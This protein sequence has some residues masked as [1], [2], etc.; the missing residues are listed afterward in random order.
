MPLETYYSQ[1]PSYS[2]E[3][4]QKAY[5]VVA[6]GKVNYWTGQEGRLFE[7]EFAEWCNCK[8][9]IALA[10][11]T[12]ALDLALKVLGIAQGDEVIVTPRSFIASVSSV[13][14]AGAIPVFA[15]VC[16]NSGN[17]TVD[18]IRE[19]LTNKTKA[20]IPVHLAGW[21]CD[22]PA[23]M[24]LAR[25]H[26]LRV[27]EDCAQAHGAKIEGQMVGTFGDIGCWS[28]CQDKIMTTA[29]EGGMVNT[30]DEALAKEM[31]SYKD[32]GKSWDAVYH[33]RHAEG[34]RWLHER[35]GTNWRMPEVQSS[36]GRLQIPKMD[37]W[38]KQRT[39]NASAIRSALQKFNRIVRAPIPAAELTHAYYRL[40]AYVNTDELSENW[41]RDAI[42]KALTELNVP[43]AHGSC[44]E[45]YLEKA[46]DNTNF[47]PKK[48]CQNAN[49]LSDSSM[50]FL[51]HPTLKAHEIQDICTKI[52]SVLAS[53]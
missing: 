48:R 25:E 3:E 27:I 38:T 9:A 20:I 4:A 46:F 10:N 34:F 35:F 15:D 36:I 39:K 31:W 13:V 37:D 50:M 23:I 2:E 24:E 5:E 17:I 47:R 29:G 52:D 44:S 32:H 18:S 53:V 43:V 33:Q 1:W 42:V 16:L 51:V 7:K 14:N 28:F 19:K 49:Q 11:G 30:N 40:Y 21:P 22:M 45:I 41:S 12:V 6:S 8:R 26:G